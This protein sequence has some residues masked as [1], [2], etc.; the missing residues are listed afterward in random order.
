[1]RGRGVPA[2][3]DTA[4]SFVPDRPWVAAP[5]GLAVDPILEDVCG[6]SVTRVFDRD[7]ADPAHARG[8]DQPVVL[9]FV[10]C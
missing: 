6:N 9:T 7:A 10:P 5:Y 4:W 3:H 2:R 8:P 1:V